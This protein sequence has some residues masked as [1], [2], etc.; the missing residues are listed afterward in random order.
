MTMPFARAAT[1]H[2][3]GRWSQRLAAGPITSAR[4]A[5]ERP[6]AS[7]ATV[8]GAVFSRSIMLTG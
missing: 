6:S 2:T 8:G 1:R 3:R 7:K 4:P 5:W